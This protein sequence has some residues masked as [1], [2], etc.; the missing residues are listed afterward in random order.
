MAAKTTREEHKRDIYDQWSLPFDRHLPA[1]KDACHKFV[2][3]CLLIDTNTA[4]F[5]FYVVNLQKT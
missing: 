1:K 5:R 4:F 2:E 3:K